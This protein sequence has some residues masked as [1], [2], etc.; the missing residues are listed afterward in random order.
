MRKVAIVC[1]S[2]LLAALP[3]TSADDAKPDPWAPVRF[4]I[5]RWEGTTQGEPGNGA[6]VRTYEFVLGSRFVHERNVSTYPP[7]AKLLDAAPTQRYVTH[8]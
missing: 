5:G 2:L 4:L 1:W 7:Q 3:A 6:V 8:H